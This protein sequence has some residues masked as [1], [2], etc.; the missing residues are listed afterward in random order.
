[1]NDITQ[2]HCNFPTPQ[3]MRMSSPVRLQ[4]GVPRSDGWRPAYGL[5]SG[6]LG[7]SVGMNPNRVMN[8]YDVRALSTLLIYANQNFRPNNNHPEF[9]H[10]SVVIY[11]GRNFC[12]HCMMGAEAGTHSEHRSYMNDHQDFSRS[13]GQRNTQGENTCVVTFN[14]GE[15]RT[16]TLFGPDGREAR[17]GNSR[18]LLQSEFPPR[19]G[20][21]GSVPRLRRERSPQH[22]TS[23]AHCHSSHKED[24]YLTS[25]RHT[26]VGVQGLDTTCWAL[27]YRGI[28]GLGRAGS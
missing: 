4:F 25:G 17:L 13:D 12:L 16:F 22:R 20:W 7:G 26:N 9:N 23:A 5:G 6:G 19:P 18:N 2:T 1:M 28:A 10:I 21:G 14:V 27:G 11:F 3:Y 8:V 24:R 15:S